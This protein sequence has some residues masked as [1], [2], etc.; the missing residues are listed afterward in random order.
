MD[1]SVSSPDKDEIELELP[2]ADGFPPGLDEPDAGCLFF[3]F[4]VCAGIDGSSFDWDITCVM[5]V[6][7]K[8]GKTK[9]RHFQEST[10]TS[11]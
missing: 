8:Y 10:I 9:H 3:F 6:L 7:S 11:L 4:F 1:V 2:I 5:S